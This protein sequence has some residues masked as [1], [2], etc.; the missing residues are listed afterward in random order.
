LEIVATFNAGNVF[1]VLDLLYKH[2]Y[3]QTGKSL[4]VSGLNSLKYRKR[5]IVQMKFHRSRS[6][7]RCDW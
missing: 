2:I 7:L 1:I 5:K 3:Q 6:R 4:F